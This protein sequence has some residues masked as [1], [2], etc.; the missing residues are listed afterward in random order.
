MEEDIHKQITEP[1][2]RSHPPLPTP[3]KIGPYKIEG[4]ISTGGMSYIYIAKHPT[5]GEAIVVKVVR[6][7][8]LKNKEMLSRL[9]NEAKVIGLTSHPNI[10]KL[11]D[12]GQ[13]E[14]G[15][16]IAMEYV[17]GV[18]LRQFI[19][20]N[21]ISH[22]RALEIVLQIAYALTH[23][24]SHGVIHR[25]LKPDNVL[26]TESG[27]IKLI[28]FGIA[29]FLQPG[30]ERITKGRARVG[31]PNYMSPEQKEN[32]DQVSF[33]TD[34]FSLGI[35]TYELYLGQMCYG[36]IRM[37][38]LPMRLRNIL[39]KCLKIDP[40][41]R[42]QDIVAF[43]S[44]ISDFMKHMDEIEEVSEDLTSIVQNTRELL[45]SQKPPS[46]PEVAIGIAVK[47]GP[48]FNSIYLDFFSLRQN[49][50]AIL[51][52]EP[53]KKTIDSLT[54]TPMLRGIARTVVKC[55]DF[56]L[57]K[58]LNLFNQILCEDP[59]HKL[60]R[61]LF[62]KLDTEKNA[63]SFASCDSTNLFH[64][65]EG[66][67]EPRILTTPN[68]AIGSDPN[69]S[70]LSTEGQWEIGSTLILSSQKGEFGG[71][72]D[73]L[74]LSAQP[75]AMKALDKLLPSQKSQDSLAVISILRM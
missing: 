61:L 5:T 24:H 20:K 54:Y 56:Q 29:Q 27:D 40:K 35:I 10:V 1:D 58:T 42:Y 32:P 68:P 25:D 64:F 53:V 48:G 6:N 43:I 51:L 55:T 17:Q 7:K 57:I 50:Y 31:T 37:N 34:I 23:L 44:D 74:M 30:D 38:L 46:W 49:Q 14:K 12:L 2:L 71:L 33:S 73:D 41:E 15:L 4:L 66:A 39:E 3:E 19:K 26:I 45:L 63:F 69:L 8:H 72:G 11:F 60:F 16:Y 75:L 21:T 9:L 52:A 13:W 18:S 22:K 47:E 28:D 62:L 70:F 59:M 36:V 67:H 65:G